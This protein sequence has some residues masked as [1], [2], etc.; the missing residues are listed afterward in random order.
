MFGF[1]S[2]SFDFRRLTIS[3]PPIQRVAR[4]SD[5]FARY[6]F[7]LRDLWHLRLISIAKRSTERSKRQTIDQP[8]TTLSIERLTTKT[9][10]HERRSRH[11]VDSGD[12]ERDERGAVRVAA[13]LDAERDQ[14]LARRSRAL[15]VRFC[16]CLYPS[17]T[18]NDDA[19]I[20]CRLNRCS[21]LFLPSRAFTDTDTASAPS[22]PT[23][24]SCDIIRRLSFVDRYL[25]FLRVDL[26]FVNYVHDRPK[27]PN[28]NCASFVCSSLRSF[29]VS[30]SPPRFR[31]AVV[32]QLLESTYRPDVVTSSRDVMPLDTVNAADKP[33]IANGSTHDDAAASAS[34]SSFLFY[35]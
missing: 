21:N 28:T 12:A 7:C 27:T 4:Q 24:R 26:V 18:T 19:L 11:G 29:I 23:R 15:T 2:V 25:I 20:A 10:R 22:P 33:T 5:A 14:A 8:R 16:L 13:P 34:T 30:S 17:S 35:F 3:R 32:G 6:V 31:L 9:K 1:V